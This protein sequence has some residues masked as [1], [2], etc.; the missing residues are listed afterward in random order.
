MYGNI[1]PQ[2]YVNVMID[3]SKN[4]SLNTTVAG[5]NASQ[6]ESTNCTEIVVV[7]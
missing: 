3:A 7:P 6:V 2:A 4:P 5:G 1:N